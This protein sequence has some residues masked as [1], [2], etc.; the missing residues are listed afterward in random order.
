MATHRE[1]VQ[2]QKSLCGQ[3]EPLHFPLGPLGIPDM[4]FLEI[5][6]DFLIDHLIGEEVKITDSRGKVQRVREGKTIK[7]IQKLTGAEILFLQGNQ[8]RTKPRKLE[9]RGSLDD[10]RLAE[11]FLRTFFKHENPSQ[12]KPSLKIRTASAIFW[13]YLSKFRN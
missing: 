13:I 3:T 9:I 5:P 7:D 12:A 4:K 2:Y 6:K 1:L 8:G 11:E 10:V